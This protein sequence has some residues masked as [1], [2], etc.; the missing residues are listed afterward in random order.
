MPN[1]NWFTCTNTVLSLASLDPIPDMPTFDAGGTALDK[2]Q[3]T[4]KTGVMLA[5]QHLGLRCRRHFSKRQFMIQVNKPAAGQN[6]IIALDLSIAAENI[7]P[8]SFFNLTNANTVVGGVNLS[9]SGNQRLENWKYEEFLRAYPNQNIIENAPPLAWIVLPIDAAN[10]TAPNNGD[11]TVQYVQIY[12]NPDQ[13]YQLIYQAKVNAQQLQK[14]TDL[15]LFPPVYEHAVWEFALYLLESDLGEGKE[16]QIGQLAKEAADQVELAAG[17]ATDV[18][19]AP[20]MMKIHTLHGLTKFYNSP[21][22][23]DA[24][25]NPT[26]WG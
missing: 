20:R 11:D 12:P 9:N 3:L 7:S 19:K 2:Y 16:M 26:T 5:N 1:S 6:C 4:A 21:L 25:G 18:R 15:I 23:I 14:S 22:S 13:T 8:H 24:N 17:T 10:F